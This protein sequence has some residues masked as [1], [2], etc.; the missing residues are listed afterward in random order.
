MVIATFLTWYIG[1]TLR[2]L[3]MAEVT[4]R[5]QSVVSTG[6]AISVE[7]LSKRFN[8]AVA[9][10]WA[11]HEVNCTV[12]VG[13]FVVL[14]GESGCGKTTLLRLI[15]GL[16]TPTTGR[17]LL[18]N[19]VVQGPTR[20][21]GFVFQR[22][23]LLA[24]RTVLDNVLLPVEL[25]RQ[26]R[27]EARHRAFELLTLLSLRDFAGHR[28]HQLSGGMQQRV[29]LA[30]ALLLQPSVLLMD[31][32]FGALDAI[33]RE[34]LNLELLKMWQHGE[35]TVMF[36]THDITEAVFLADRVLL[37]SR[38]PGTIAHAFPVPLPRPRT[39]EMRFERRFTDL[40]HTIHQAMGLLQQGAL[41]AD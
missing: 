13:E 34:Q 17:V 16:D 19:Q 12:Q 40:C 10:L 37:M 2:R 26:S 6:S 41:Y 29:A 24:W 11:L 35:Q 14:V 4:L 9:D 25:T 18:G 22:P 27:L 33:T 3:L 23:V 8:G 15:A 7:R 39:L 28:P 1:P 36:I 21:I 32:P 20:E 38:R 30:R 5:Q 31:E